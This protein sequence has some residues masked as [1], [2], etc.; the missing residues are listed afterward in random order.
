MRRFDELYRELKF[1]FLKLSSAGV[2]LDLEG[3]TQSFF[4]N[5]ELMNKPLSAIVE[6]IPENIWEEE[7]NQA[8]I[9]WISG[10]IKKHVIITSIKTEDGFQLILQD[11]SK[12][13]PPILNYNHSPEIEAIT[14]IPQEI[15]NKAKAA[16]SSSLPVLISGETGTGKEILARAIHKASE[17]KGEFIH[18][19]CS[20]IPENLVESELFGYEPGAFTGAKNSGK[21]GLIKKADGGTLFLDEI[22]EL[23]VNL[24][25]KLLTAIETGKYFRL[26]GH[27]EEKVKFRLITATN[28]NLEKLLE[29]GKFRKDLFYRINGIKITIPPLRERTEHIEDFINLFISKHR[30]NIHFSPEAIEV[31]KAYDWPGNVRELENCIRYFIATGNGKQIS[32]SEVKN[33]LKVDKNSK[34]PETLSEKLKALKHAEIKKALK[35][36]NGNKTKAAKEL[37][38]TRQGLIKMM[39]SLGIAQE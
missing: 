16:A 2:I 8:E 27:I 18:I 24:Q 33:R 22:A 32:A 3:D 9:V 17:F 7:P 12:F 13:N 15:K 39:K 11:S 26:G 29:G 25:A 1:L 34:S 36:H 31:M 21:P 30:G 10:N 28:R 37:G 4:E 20:S 35:K 38:I 14:G 6:I 5:S 19:N 23:P